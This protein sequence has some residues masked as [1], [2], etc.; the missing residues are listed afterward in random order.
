MMCKVSAKVCDLCL[1]LK[2]SIQSRKVEYECQAARL[3]PYCKGKALKGNREG[4]CVSS[5]SGINVVMSCHFVQFLT[6]KV[7]ML[8]EH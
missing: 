2:L 1:Q 7:K 6:A 5:I 8:S 4:L 3:E